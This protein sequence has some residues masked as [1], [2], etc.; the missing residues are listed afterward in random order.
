M[1]RNLLE[2]FEALGFRFRIIGDMIDCEF[3]GTSYPKEWA[4]IMSEHR[5]Y[6]ANKLMERAQK[7]AR[8]D[9]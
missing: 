5:V 6:L 1:S 3:S 2:Q 4:D 7:A 9:K 8:G